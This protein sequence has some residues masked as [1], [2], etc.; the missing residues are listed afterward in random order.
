MKSFNVPFQNPRSSTHLL[1][2]GKT[3]ILNKNLRVGTQSHTDLTMHTHTR[4][5][6]YNLTALSDEVNKTALGAADDVLYVSSYVL[7][8]TARYASCIN[9]KSRVLHW[10]IWLVAGYTD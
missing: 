4:A 2:F 9:F 6:T 3:K 5:G 7:K 8:Q 1:R 10:A